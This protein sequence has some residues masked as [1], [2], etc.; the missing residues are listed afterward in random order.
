MDNKPV[1]D[2]AQASAE[3][4]KRLYK[5][6]LAAAK[7]RR[8]A[9]GITTATALGSYVGRGIGPAIPTIERSIAGP[10]RKSRFGDDQPEQDDPMHHRNGG[11]E[12]IGISHD[13]SP[14]VRLR[15]A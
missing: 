14:R 5:A 11:N 4:C 6:T 15:V 9:V 13:I 2:W 7:A 3:Q 10:L 1:E 8:E 12:Q